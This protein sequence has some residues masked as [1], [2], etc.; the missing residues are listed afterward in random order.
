MLVEVH[1]RGF[2]AA[3]EI[4]HLT[5]AAAHNVRLDPR[6][7]HIELVFDA[8]EFEG[9][10]YWTW[11]KAEADTIRATLYGSPVDVLQPPADQRAGSVDLEELVAHA[12]EHH[13]D[14]LAFDRWV[15][16]NL[17]QLDD[18]VRERVRPQAVPG[19]RSTGLQAVWD[20]WTDGRLRL[21]QH[22][23]MSQAE[24]R[25]LFFRTFAAHGLLLPRH[26]AT[27]HDLWEGR[28]D[29]QDGLIRCLDRLPSVPSHTA[30]VE[31]GRPTS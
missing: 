22:P 25:R 8:P 11:S 26:W 20:V 23:G 13:V 19:G 14:R 7:S 4:A 12:E 1:P 2:P 16:R 3:T 6:V 10:G 28:V 31:T 29:D 9:Q 24:R 15:H 18:I 17:L 5:V 30:G 27:F 21:W